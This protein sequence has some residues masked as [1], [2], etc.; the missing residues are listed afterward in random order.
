[1]VSVKI[2][3]GEILDLEWSTHFFL[4]LDYMGKERYL[5]GVILDPVQAVFKILPSQK[6]CCYK[7]YYSRVRYTIS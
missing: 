6:F 7:K 1:M 4:V 2:G 5:I 3:A